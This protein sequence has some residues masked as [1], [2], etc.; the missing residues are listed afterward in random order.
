LSQLLN[1]F[2]VNAGSSAVAMA[3]VLHVLSD[4]LNTV[5][6]NLQFKFN[7]FKSPTNFFQ[8][9][10]IESHCPYREATAPDHAMPIELTGNTP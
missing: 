10:N 5:D 6:R 3:S 1:V 4:T 2:F 8:I 9:F 7:T